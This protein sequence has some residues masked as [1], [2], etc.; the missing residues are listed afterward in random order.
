[1]IIVNKQSHSM[2]LHPFIVRRS[3][4]LFY[5]ESML[6]TQKQLFTINSTYL[7]LC[8]RCYCDCDWKKVLNMTITCFSSH[9]TLYVSFT[10]SIFCDTLFCS[11]SKLLTVDMHQSFFYAAIYWLKKFFFFDPALEIFSKNCSYF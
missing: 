5:Y 8:C 10:D 2:N 11:F 3:F 6:S 9:L 4:F 7:N 1:M